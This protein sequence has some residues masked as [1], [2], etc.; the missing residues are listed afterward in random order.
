MAAPLSPALQPALGACFTSC[1]WKS[2]K[3]NLSG[4]NRWLKIGALGAVLVASVAHAEKVRVGYWTSGVSL[5]FG[6][7]LEAGDF[8][9]QQGIDAEFVHFA[10][11][12]AP[13]R[14]L[15]ANAIDLSFGAAAASI[16]SSA[17]DGVPI[18]IIAATQ[19]ADVDFVVPVDSP[20]KSID[21][22]RGKKIGMSPEGSS[23][24]SI[25]QAVL[26]GNHNI[27][28]ADFT[29]IPGNDSRL[30]QFL[31]QK[32]VDGA[33]LRS[34]TMLQLKDLKVRKLGSFAD[35]WD[36]MTHLGTVPYI[37]V[38]AVRSE[39]VDKTPD[40]AAK[41]IVAMKNALAW[42]SSHPKEVTAIMEKSANLPAA[43]AEAYATLWDRMNKVTFE[44]TD[45]VTLTREH[46]LFVDSGVLKGALPATL[47]A[48]GPFE[49]ARK[50]K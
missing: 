36:K 39:M 46:Q 16:F 48:T 27:K 29:L 34:V 31:V 7:V 35:E 50:M 17:S 9:K 3:M 45:V 38:A 21:E 43:D 25:A 10:D 6:A 49:Q 28:A 1:I 11:V 20:I 47:F 40:T 15:A 42:G 12:N 22:F 24:A 44:K 13:T 33:A 5:G 4:L 14:A 26:A 30:A 19:P 37:G 8:F 18:K 32:Q 23:V 2:L 41:V